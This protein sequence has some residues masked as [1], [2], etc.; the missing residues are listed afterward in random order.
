M[1]KTQQVRLAEAKSIYEQLQKIGIMTNDEARFK[2]KIASN[3]YI[4][5]GY[6]SRFRVKVDDKCRAIVHFCGE[7]S[8]QSGVILEYL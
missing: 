7:G 5:T 4:R 6:S 3:E 1:K 2:L 8:S